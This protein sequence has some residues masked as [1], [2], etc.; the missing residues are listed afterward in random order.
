MKW[1]LFIDDER[2]PVKPDCVIARSSMEAILMVG[3]YGLPTH[4]DFDHDLKILNG[5]ADTAMEF[6]KWL[7]NEVVDGKIDIPAE[8]TF[9][10]HSQNPVGAENIRSRMNQLLQHYQKD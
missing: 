6:V 5:V 1:K 2:F 10:V 7:E 3:H 8:F 9:A 4:I